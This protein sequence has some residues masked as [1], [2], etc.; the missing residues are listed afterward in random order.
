[1]FRVE[2][3]RATKP[4]P[5]PDGT[6]AATRRGPLPGGRNLPPQPTSR[7]SKPQMWVR[8]QAADWGGSDKHPSAPRRAASSCPGSPWMRSHLSSRRCDGI[9]HL[10]AFVE[11]G[12][13]ASCS[14][15]AGVPAAE[16]QVRA[17]DRGGRTHICGLGRSRAR[18]EGSPP[19]VCRVCTPPQIVGTPPTTPRFVGEV[20]R[21]PK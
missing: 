6:P 20:R 19:R 17:G 18:E 12:G 3:L 4:P 16:R 10:A 15:D 7:P 11:G 8:P 9:G 13:R 1:M 21:C 2:S 5:V 14:V